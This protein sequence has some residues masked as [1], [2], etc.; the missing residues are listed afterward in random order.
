MRVSINL[1]KVV[2]TVVTLGLNLLLARNRAAKD[3]ALH[4]ALEDVP[5]AIELGPKDGGPHDY[6]QFPK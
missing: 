1:R 6:H 5:S 3:R 2:T 4:Q